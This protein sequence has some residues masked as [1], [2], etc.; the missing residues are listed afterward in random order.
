MFVFGCMVEYAIVHCAK[1]LEEESEQQKKKG[2]K[3][4]VSLWI[5]IGQNDLFNLDF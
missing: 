5:V 4:I 1:R 2:N 3:V